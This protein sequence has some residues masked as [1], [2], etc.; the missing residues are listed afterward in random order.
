MTE[1]QIAR[2]QK[3]ILIFNEF[4]ESDQHVREFCKKRNIAKSQF[5]QWRIKLKITPTINTTPDQTSA[6]REL[7]DLPTENSGLHLDFNNGSKLIINAG[8][9]QSTLHRVIEVLR[10]C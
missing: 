7:S 10:E 1:R 8:F 5:Y 3:W 9:D 2:N 6:F 4:N